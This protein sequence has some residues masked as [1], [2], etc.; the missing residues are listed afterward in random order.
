MATQTL[1]MRIQLRRATTAEWEA[2]KSVVPA[3]GEPCFDIELNTLKIGD[4]TKTYEELKSIGGAEVS[5][6]GK[7]IVLNDGVFKLSGFDAAETGAQPRKKAD[8]TIEWVVPSTETV[9]GL[10]TTVAGLQSDVTEIQKILTPAE[11]STLLERVEGLE[12]K[13]GEDT[14]DA[15]ITAAINKFATDVSDDDVVNTYKELIDY[16]AN[17]KGEAASMAA[18]ITTLQETVAKIEAGAQVNKIEAVKLGPTLLE[19]VDKTV[20]IPIGAGLKFSDEISVSED[21]TVNISKINV[22]KLVQDDGSDFV[23]DGGSAS[24]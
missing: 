20:T 8:G 16:A 19:I 5:A 11:G 9:E 1:R 14:V 3:A 21:G 13:V 10:Q 22:S 6:D 15:K 7:S 4:G 24:N 23:L 18:D 12:T 2:N 17:H